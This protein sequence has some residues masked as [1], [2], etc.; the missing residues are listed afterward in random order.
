MVLIKCVCFE[1]YTFEKDSWRVGELL[2]LMITLTG[3]G[4]CK[5]GGR[6]EGWGM[7][8]VYMR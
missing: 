8:Y 1:E 6:C 3:R 2:K 7:G 5:G 4:E